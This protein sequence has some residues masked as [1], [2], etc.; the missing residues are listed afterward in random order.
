MISYESVITGSSP[1]LRSQ[2]KSR[3]EVVKYQQENT[4]FLCTVKVKSICIAIYCNRLKDHQQKIKANDFG[5]F[6]MKDQQ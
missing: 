4:L 2:N 5:A 1:T 3:C 6:V